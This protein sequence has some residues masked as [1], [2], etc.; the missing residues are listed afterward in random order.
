M[1]MP[2]SCFDEEARPKEILQTTARGRLYEWSY[3]RHWPDL[4]VWP[5]ESPI[6]SV[7]RSPGRCTAGAQ[8]GGM[9]GRADRL[10]GALAA[11]IRAKETDEAIR[12]LPKDGQ[13]IVYAMYLVEKRERPRSWREA[14]KRCNVALS[15]Y[16]DAMERAIK[17]LNVELCLGVDKVLTLEPVR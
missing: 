8:D 9:S 7:W 12:T 2:V 16:Q 6:Y 17:L 1:T 13:A 5:P 15:T 14:A 4:D 11:V 3:V 10:S